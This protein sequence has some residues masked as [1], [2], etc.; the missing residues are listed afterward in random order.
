MVFLSS[1]I[2]ANTVIPGV[3]IT[4]DATWDLAGSPYYIE[5]DVYVENA[6]DLIIEAGVEVRFNGSYSLCIGNGTLT[7][8]GDASNKIW[9]TSN[10]SSP[11]V[12]NWES[13]KVNSTGRI[14]LNYCNITYGNY[15][16]D[17]D[18]S[19]N[20]SI[21]NSEIII[22]Y[23]GFRVSL[24]SNTTIINNNVSD[25][26]YTGIFIR[27]CTDS[28]IENNIV[29]SNSWNGVHIYA[30]SDISVINNTVDDNIWRGVYLFDSTFNNISEN[31]IYS[32]SGGILVHVTSTNNNI[33]KNNIS[34]NSNFGINLTTSNNNRI[35]HNIFWYNSLQAY[36]ASLSNF[37]DNG[38]PSGGNY[39]S[40]FDE[41]LE[42]AYDNLSGPVQDESGADGIVDSE[43][44]NIG[45]GVGIMDN[46]PLMNPGVA[47]TYVYLDSPKNNSVVVPGT[48]LDFIV[49][50]EDID[51]VNYSVDG[52][53]NVTLDLPY[54]INDTV[55]GGWADG[56]HIIEIFV[57]DMYGKMEEFWFNITI[58]SILPEIL[59]NTPTL[60][61]LIKPGVYIDLTV[62]DDNL[63]L[64]NYEM[65]GGPNQTISFPYDI[66]TS[67]WPDG[68]RTIVVYAKDLA[69]NLNFTAYNFTIDG[70][71]PK[72]MLESPT[73]NNSVYSPGTILFFNITDDHL[74]TGTVYYKKN[75][76][77]SENFNYST[78]FEINTTGWPDDTYIIEVH[79]QDTLGNENIRSFTFD[80][81][82]TPPEIL[83][84]TPFNNSIFQAGE[85]Q[86]N[87]LINEGHIDWVHIYENDVFSD[88]FLP[89]YQW[90]TTGVADGPY[91]IKI[92][93][94]DLAGNFAT[95]YFNFTVA[96][97]PKIILD[98]PSN[99][100]LIQA[101]IHIELT[102]TDT[103]LDYVY[104]TLNSGS[105]Q[106]LDPPHDINTTGWADGP[107]WVA[108]YAMDTAGNLNTSVYLFTLDSSP[109]Q[110]NL[111]T[112][113]NNSYI[114]PGEIIQFEI[115]E[116]NL[117]SVTNSTNGGLFNTFA[118]P[119]R[120]DT[121]GW[122]DGVYTFTIK[123]SDAL[124]AMSERYF[125]LTIDSV[126]PQIS[127]I[128]PPDGSSLEIGALIN[129][130]IME[131][132]LKFVNYTVNS[133]DKGNI[134][135][136]FSIDT[137]DF[138]DGSC[139]I[140][141][142]AEDL[143]GNFDSKE[144]TFIFNDTTEPEINLLSPV[145]I[146]FIVDGTAIEFEIFDLF[147]RNAS[148]SRDSD[149]P[150]EFSSP[151]IIDTTGWSEGLH[152]LIIRAYDTRNNL[153]QK[154]YAVTIDSTIPLIGLDT[155]QNNSVILTGTE[156]RFV[157][158][159]DNLDSVNYSINGG[160]WMQLPAP[161]V[162]GT[163][164]W[165]D[166]EYIIAIRVRDKAGNRIIKTYRFI[167]DSTPPSIVLNQPLNGSLVRMD[168]IIDFSILDDNVNFVT[169]YINGAE[170]SFTGPYDLNASEL[171]QGANTIRIIAQDMAQNQKE[172]SFVFVLDSIPPEVSN[173]FAA[174]PYYPYNHT[175]VIITFSE[176]MNTN[177]VEDAL[178][179]SSDVQYTLTWYNNGQELWL[180]NL[181]G[182]EYDK[183][184]TVDFDDDVYDLAGNPLE[185]FTGY[186]FIATIDIYLDTDGDRMPDGWEFYY[187]LDPDD[188][189]DAERDLDGDSY[190]NLEE[191][192]GGSDPTDSDSIPREDDTGELNLWW[193]I[194][195]LIAL[196]VISIVLFVF[197]LRE[198][199]EEPKGPVEEVE[200]MY[201]AMR[202]KEDIAKME[203]ILADK[204]KLGERNFEAEIMV[205]KAKE[206]LDKGDYNV[207]TVY[208]QT[209]RNLLM[210]IGDM[211]GEGEADSEDKEPKEDESE[212]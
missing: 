189:S 32:N 3:V 61:A 112:H 121:F 19:Q 154:E 68:N 18:Q 30:S 102:I 56:S 207:I 103:N 138:P 169:Y 155:P 74:D 23:Q 188:S 82:S 134:T 35:H 109:P 106:I 204:V 163:D 99:N 98:S 127:L 60:G 43:Y 111:I 140:V 208:E 20:N 198:R 129:L 37:W 152:T 91:N 87:F 144:Y 197:L 9:F 202:A 72:I 175:R 124:G 185:N 80:I 110:I 100:S 187:G 201:L 161:Y 76:G 191:F 29:Y 69:G 151:Y 93:A 132:N 200:D 28:K 27:E 16:I 209:L 34:G 24:S 171:D 133:Q 146:S 114:L 53:V 1:N 105:N 77:P 170:Y 64:V 122:S 48:I 79:A 85:Q 57:Y 71:I 36:D 181:V 25:N 52:G 120:I 33:T 5:G 178:S 174:Q 12:G 75:G 159:D 59:L 62:I 176:P 46:Y 65:D 210:E 92:N 190:T 38:Y 39:W 145:D 193:I 141:V 184:Y 40:D 73:M 183:L 195:I 108:I 160:S 128:S 147:F 67:L 137:N 126:K 104:Y 88:V 165:E 45:G 83:L 50:G 81:D 142:Y 136:P 107:Y 177:S 49:I 96:T 6:A 55:T 167:I 117:I 89:P 10:F 31:H 86:L 2:E 186:S 26:S 4:A 150:I 179:V 139:N 203:E 180:D 13:I 47:R 84:V 118:P 78:V 95:A 101:G 212:E 113:S 143:A 11:G 153:N 21:Q 42:G 205:E 166:N 115:I 123:A 14:D 192:L 172:A 17:I 173:I 148:Y 199:K 8:I 149:D 63:D 58:D 90:N 44:L 131:T 194:P 164:G 7:A 15:A 158:F 206:A 97:L 116:D 162:I 66:D 22:N 135:S 156:L 168:S 119:Y 51:Y 94:Q 125:R 41:A 157:P 196:L 182:L 130:S 70:M 54:D 211:E